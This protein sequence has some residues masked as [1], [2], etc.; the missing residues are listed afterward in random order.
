MEPSGL[1]IHIPFCKSIC[2][3]CDF[4]K[5]KASDELMEKYEEAVVSA[6]ASLGILYSSSVFDT[7]YFGGGTPSCMPGSS[8]ASI[9]EALRSSFNISSDCEITV[10]CNPSSP[11]KS[12]IPSVAAAGVNRIS[13][14]MQSAIDSE[15]RSLGRMADCVRVNQAL[16][17]CRSAGISNISLDLMLGV[18][19]QTM[20]SLK[21]SLS[22]A[23]NSGVPHVSAYMLKL[24]E[25]T[26]FYKRK[27]SLD[28]PSEDTVCD[29][30]DMT[31]SYLEGAGL[32]QYEISNFGLPSR[33][34][35]KYWKDVPY[36]GIG[37]GAHSCMDGKRFYYPSDVV[38]F[39]KGDLKCV[40]D[41]TSGSL[42]ERV[43]LG[44]R[45][46]SGIDFLDDIALSK[47]SADLTLAPYVKISSGNLSLT[48]EGFL[49]SNIVIGKII[50][51]L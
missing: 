33:H 6:T 1:Y 13:M 15:R 5:V 40:P 29:M 12:F 49:V 51:K 32:T 9:I 47:I 24:E 44:L 46:T 39:I 50:E 19:G 42:E 23:I 28:L 3:Y 35:L 43:M 20:S 41:G 48:H 4:Y 26:V 11:L 14:G 36:L 7:I 10:E 18:P 31:C 21:T 38:G 34:N 37:P 45:L 22:Y 27:D 8:I 2:P 30:Y 16:S 25:G 17:I